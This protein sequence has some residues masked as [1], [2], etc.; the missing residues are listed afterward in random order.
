[1][2]FKGQLH[3]HKSKAIAGQELDVHVVPLYEQVSLH[4]TSSP[5]VF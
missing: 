3:L 1:M 5:T 2:L 4:V